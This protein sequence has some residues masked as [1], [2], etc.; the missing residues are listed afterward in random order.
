MYLK[1]LGDLDLVSDGIDIAAVALKEY[2]ISRI[3]PQARLTPKLE[4]ALE[5]IDILHQIAGRLGKE[6]SE[7]KVRY[8]KLLDEADQLKHLKDMLDSAQCEDKGA[9]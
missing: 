5:A 7:L 4:E 9:K 6:D 3:R 1:K 2:A 8:A